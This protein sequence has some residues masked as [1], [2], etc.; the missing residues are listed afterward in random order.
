MIMKTKKI[1]MILMM[2]I[3]VS[4]GGDDGNSD[5]KGHSGYGNGDDGGGS[6]KLKNTPSFLL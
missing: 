3:L 2:K 5:D 4:E 6:K 1:N